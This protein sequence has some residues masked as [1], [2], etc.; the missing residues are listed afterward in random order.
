MSE[1]KNPS[2]PTAAGPPATQLETRSVALLP[3]QWAWLDAQPRSAGASLRQLVNNARRD[4]H[5]R[6]R[7]ERLKEDCYYLMRDL[8]GD[9]PHFEEA[10]RAL[11]GGDLFRLGSLADGWPPEV[12]QPI[13]DLAAQAW[14][15]LH[16]QG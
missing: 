10:C 4:V 8:A 12:A 13:T 11:F 6:H 2:L 3:R 16:G 1:I 9:R 5:G 14:N 7:A 15:P